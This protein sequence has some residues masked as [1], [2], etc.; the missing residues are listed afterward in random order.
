MPRQTFIT[1]DFLVNIPEKEVKQK[2]LTI[3][4]LVDN[5]QLIGEHKLGQY[6]KF[7]YERPDSKLNHHIDVSTLPL[8]EAQTKVTIHASYTS[9][10][11]FHTDPYVSNALNNFEAAVNAVLNDTI[12]NFI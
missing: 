8:T 9:G 10:M 5:V 6:L 3:P 4:S 7:L 11:S 1:K 2:I 12:G